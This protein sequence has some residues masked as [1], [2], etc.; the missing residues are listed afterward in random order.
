MGNGCVEIV[1]RFYL[2][3]YY[4]TVKSLAAYRILQWHCEIISHL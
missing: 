1:V 4:G 2:N 3:Y